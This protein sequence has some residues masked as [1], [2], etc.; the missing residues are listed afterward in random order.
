MKG[1]SKPFLIHP[2]SFILSM[3]VYFLLHF[4]FSLRVVPGERLRRERWALPTIAL[5]GARTFLPQVALAA[6]I[7]PARGTFLL[8]Q[9]RSRLSGSRTMRASA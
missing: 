2:S 7:R 4:P 5:Y 9:S 8:Y 1:E 3:A 6:T